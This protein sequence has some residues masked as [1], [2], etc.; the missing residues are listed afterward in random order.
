[1][2]GSEMG[3]PVSEA[4]MTLKRHGLSRAEIATFS[5]E[6]RPTAATASVVAAIKHSLTRNQRARLRTRQK[7]I[8][9]AHRVMA[10]KGVEAATINEITE[11][12]DVGFGSFYNYFKSKEEIAHAV[13]VAQNSELGEQFDLLNINVFDP[14]RKLSRNILRMAEKTRQDPVFGWFHLHARTALQDVRSVFW[15]RMMANL[16]SG[17]R[18]G[19]YS[20]RD[21]KITGDILFGAIFAMMRSIL[22]G[23]VDESAERQ[24]VELVMRML[25]VP[26]DEA[27]ALACEA[28]PEKGGSVRPPKVRL[29]VR[30]KQNGKSARIAPA[31]SRKYK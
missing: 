21:A 24:V 1:M 13:F 31:A 6:L 12:A 15:G 5:E 17:L 9:A 8:D 11:E 23:R 18:E 10:R 14:R 20:F 26:H 3:S 4:F 22:E 16:K 29:A 27:A 25:G 7:L 19:E 28:L 2:T 30:A